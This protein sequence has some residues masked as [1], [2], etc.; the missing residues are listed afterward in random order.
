MALVPVTIGSSRLVEDPVAE[1]VRIVRTRC[2]RDPEFILRAMRDARTVA[3]TEGAVR[4]ILRTIPGIYQMTIRLG[5]RR[6]KPES[7]TYS[8]ITAGKFPSELNYAGRV[9]QLDIVFLPWLVNDKGTIVRKKNVIP[10]LTC[11][12]V[13]S[14]YAMVKRLNDTKHDHVFSM[15]NQHFLPVIYDKFDEIMRLDA[16]RVRSGYYTEAAFRARCAAAARDRVEALTEREG[17][18]GREARQREGR[19]IE[20]L[21]ARDSQRPRRARRTVGYYDEQATMERGP[22]GAH[23]WPADGPFIRDLDL[24]GLPIKRKFENYKSGNDEGARSKNW[25]V[26]LQDMQ[27]R[28][29]A[30]VS[31]ISRETGLVDQRALDSRASARV[32]VTEPWHR[33]HPHVTFVTDDGEFGVARARAHEYANKRGYP[34]PHWCTVNKTELPRKGVQIVERFHRT[35]RAMWAISLTMQTAADPSVGNV[36]DVLEK[37]IPETYNATRSRSTMCTPDE[38]WRFLVDG[39]AQRAHVSMR[40]AFPPKTLVTVPVLGKTDETHPVVFRTAEKVFIVVGKNAYTREIAEYNTETKEVG[41]VELKLGPIA[42]HMLRAITQRNAQSLALMNLDKVSVPRLA[43]GASD[44]RQVRRELVDLARDNNAAGIGP[45]SSLALV[46]GTGPT[47]SYPRIDEVEAGEAVETERSEEAEGAV[48][49]LTRKGLKFLKDNATKV[50]R[51]PSLPEIDGLTVAEAIGADGA[52]GADTKGYIT[53]RALARD[54]RNGAATLEAPYGATR[55]PNERIKM[56]N[57][58]KG[59]SKKS[60]QKVTQKK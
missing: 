19:Q 1:I 36:N 26:D 43:L 48:V 56:I 40:S 14:R 7:R 44:T 20:G 52:I 42:P 46:Q 22:F 3:A 4:R 11:V 45:K 32:E 31:D 58:K 59:P 16:D 53:A 12:C 2:T 54:I 27:L 33:V 38:M 21:R 39:T 18:E 13:A 23:D 51:N 55:G 10:V 25:L 29:D 47:S 60:D 49:A 17:R 6:A 35:L 50:I 24:Y 34:A 37:L 30:G 5:A 41:D 8:S 9:F 15:M 57:E 28:S